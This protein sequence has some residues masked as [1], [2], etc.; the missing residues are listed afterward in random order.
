MKREITYLIRFFLDELLPPIIRDNR[1][2]IKPLFLI[3]YGKAY[4]ENMDFKS[5]VYKMRPDE[6]NDHYKL[7]DSSITRKR[8]TDLTKTSL[9]WIEKQLENIE[10]DSILDVGSGSEYL[11]NHLSL[12]KTFKR[13]SSIDLYEINSNKNTTVERFIGCLPNLPFKNNE[14]DIVT[15]T[16]V[17]EHVLEP[18]KSAKE[19]LRVTRKK[20]IIIVPRQRYY[21]YT[22]D[23]HIN[24]YQDIEP[25]LHLFSGNKTTHQVIKGDW[26]IS[27]EKNDPF[28][29]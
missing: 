12:K 19:L 24:F 18:D 21:K 4:K 25:L 1:F 9:K 3:A 2:F 22:L 20:L 23:N 10:L 6:L 15:C 13:L 16:H 27:I 28:N 5:K 26:V 14:F 17:L 11:L 29:D 7:L 8:T